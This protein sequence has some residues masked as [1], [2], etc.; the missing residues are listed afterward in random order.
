MNYTLKNE[1]IYNETKASFWHFSHD[2]IRKR[3]GL[4][5]SLRDLHGAEFIDT[6]YSSI[7]VIMTESCSTVNGSS[8]GITSNLICSPL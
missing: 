4:F 3:S 7:T 8:F 6:L 2:P 5:Y 1:I